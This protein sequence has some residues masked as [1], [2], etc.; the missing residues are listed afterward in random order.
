MI[1]KKGIDKL[2]I[3]LFSL[4]PLKIEFRK[5]KLILNKINIKTFNPNAFATKTILDVLL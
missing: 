2:L 5:V 3:L 4:L 1:L